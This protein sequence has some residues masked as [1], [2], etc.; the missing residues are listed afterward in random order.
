MSIYEKKVRHIITFFIAFVFISFCNLLYSGEKSG[1]VRGGF[2]IDKGNSKKESP[3]NK[4]SVND[5]QK[6]NQDTAKATDKPNNAKS[7]EKT[8]V[9][10]GR[11]LFGDKRK[12]TS[13]T[14]NQTEK[15]NQRS[16][17]EK[18]TTSVNKKKKTSPKHKIDYTKIYF[19]IISALILFL[20]LIFGMKKRGRGGRGRSGSNANR[21]LK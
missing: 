3:D 18:K 12:N 6:K 1:I 14:K 11:I 20:Y 4:K 9:T 21:Y 8:G 10:K 13:D 7:S 2:V 15:N 17:T 5:N 16:K 19:V